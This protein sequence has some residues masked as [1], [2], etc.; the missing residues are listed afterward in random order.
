MLESFDL[1]LSPMLE[2]PQF[3]T[4]SSSLFHCAT[5]YQ[6]LEVLDK[7]LLGL[8]EQPLELRHQG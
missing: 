6:D 4:H 8:D 2:E 3:S 1:E 5:G 7:K